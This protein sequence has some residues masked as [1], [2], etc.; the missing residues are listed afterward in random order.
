MTTSLRA[1]RNLTMHMN[2]RTNRALSSILFALALSLLFYFAFPDTDPSD[3]PTGGEFLE[4]VLTFGVPLVL[5]YLL[6]WYL[7]TLVKVGD[8]SSLRS[9]PVVP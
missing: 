4:I 9:R 8:A 7:R 3:V 5:S 2:N 1:W 6:A